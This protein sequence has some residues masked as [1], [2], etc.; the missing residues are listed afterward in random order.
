MSSF[1]RFF[2]KIVLS[3][4]ADKKTTAKTWYSFLKE[5]GVRGDYAAIESSKS[6]S[7]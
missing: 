6:S 7:V 3:T 1:I 4:I 2:T 5:S